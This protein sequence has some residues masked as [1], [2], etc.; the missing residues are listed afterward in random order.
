MRAV[1]SDSKGHQVAAGTDCEVDN[2]IDFEVKDKYLNPSLATYY[3]HDLGPNTVSLGL[4]FS[5]GCINYIFKKG[6]EA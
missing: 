2:N 1:F 3:P 6:D 4:C 5:L